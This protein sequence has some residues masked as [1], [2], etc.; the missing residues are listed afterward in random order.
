MIKKVCND[1]QVVVLM[2]GLGTRLNIA[3]PKS[4]APVQGKPFFQYQLE[5]MR[6]KGFHRF[7]FCVGE[8][9]EEIKEYFRDGKWLGVEIEYLHD[10]E[11]LLGTGGAIRHA[12]PMLDHHFMVIYG[13]SFMDIDYAEIILKFYS[14]VHHS[15]GLMTIMYNN[16]RYDKSNVE[17]HEGKIYDYSKTKPTARMRYI[18]YGISIFSSV[19][20]EQWEE[21]SFD[22]S[23]VHQMLI[24]YD[25]LSVHIVENRFYEIGSRGALAEFVEYATYRW[26]APKKAIFLDRDGI[27][28]QI[29][30]NDDIEQ[31]DSPLNI[32]QVTWMPEAIS[33]LRALQELG[34]QLFI[35]TNQPAAAKGKTTYLQLCNVNSFIIHQLKQFGIDITGY[36]ICPH[37]PERTDRTK[38]DYLI[39]DCYCRK[40]K[41]GMIFNISSDHNINFDKSWMVG[42]AW[43]DIVCGQKAGLST[44][45][46]GNFKC[47]TCAALYDK[48]DLICKDLL[49][50]ARKLE[51]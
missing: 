37:Y 21:E 43:T 17:Y 33:G 6:N 10:G 27:I 48:P 42:D 31:F 45:F 12:L 34:Y 40:P 7:V 44:A 14:E 3:Q 24:K 13:D 4:L 47:D 1:M 36:E 2:G 38:E 26:Y 9:A 29:V 50:F 23:E 22:L 11:K 32:S 16:D 41:P 25:L 46:V 51:V 30:W 15:L 20:F 39:T 35:V 8:G 28:N 19:A 49:D 5:L 18:D